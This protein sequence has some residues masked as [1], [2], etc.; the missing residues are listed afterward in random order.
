MDSMRSTENGAPFINIFTA[1]YCQSLRRLP[2][3]TVQTSV[4]FEADIPP[5]T[6][7]EQDLGIA[8]LAFYD[9]ALYRQNK[10]P[11]AGAL[12][13]ALDALNVAL[14]P[15]TDRGLPPFTQAHHDMVV[16]FRQVA[17]SRG[18]ETAELHDDAQKA[19]F[20]GSN[21]Q[22]LFGA[23]VAAIVNTNLKPEYREC[24]PLI[25][26][27]CS[28]SGGIIGPGTQ[29]TWVA[30]VAVKIY[31]QEAAN[32]HAV[33]HDAGGYAWNAI[34]LGPGYTYAGGDHISWFGL[35]LIDCRRWFTS[36][37]PAADP[38][39]GQINGLQLWKRLLKVQA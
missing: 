13:A 35:R 9:A 1:A 37:A 6:S 32:Y 3:R 29:N 28:P 14:A 26:V 5:R 24:H 36:W 39:A 17:L 16:L 23:V 27:F 12:A 20:W 10:T 25:G 8:I 38:T 34:G 22:L 15:Y 33:C 31:G 18:H 30:D 4:P 7:P 2:I 21:R 19:G 11:T